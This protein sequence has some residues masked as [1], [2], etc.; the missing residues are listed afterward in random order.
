MLRFGSSYVWDKRRVFKF[1]DPPRT[2]KETSKE[3]LAADAGTKHHEK[4]TSSSERIIPQIPYFLD[5]GFCSFSFLTLTPPAMSMLTAPRARRTRSVFFASGERICS[6][7]KKIRRSIPSRKA[8]RP[9]CNR[10]LGAS[11]GNLYKPGIFNIC[12]NFKF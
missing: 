9:R 10:L 7:G 8:S 1:H 11:K 2:A 5:C 12:K 4:G 6:P 3:T